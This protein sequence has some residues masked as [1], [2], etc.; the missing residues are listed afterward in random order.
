MTT[1]YETTPEA[2]STPAPETTAHSTYETPKVEYSTEAITEASS[3][4][5]PTEASSYAA[6][7]E[8][9]TTKAAYWA[10][11]QY[12]LIKNI[13]T[14]NDQYNPNGLSLRS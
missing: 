13:E 1:Q 14:K 5:A 10:V 11:S 9:P 12:K 7:T 2:A 8:A 6:P 4:A 3:Y